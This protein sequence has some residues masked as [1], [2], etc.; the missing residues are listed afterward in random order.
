MPTVAIRPVSEPT[1]LY[2]R[3]ER[4][5]HPQPAY[6]ALDLADGELYADYQADN[7]IPARIWYGVVRTWPIP[8]LAGDEANRLMEHIAPL[9]QRVLDGAS[10]ELGEREANRVGVLNEDAEQAEEQIY[11]EI[12]DW[13]EDP[14][15]QVVEEINVGDWY[16]HG[17]DPCEELGLTAETTDDELPG[18]AA[19]IEEDICLTAEGVV[20]VRGALEWARDRRDELRQELRDQ[21][22]QVVAEIEERLERRDELVRRLAACGDSTRAIGDLAG[23]SHTQVRR[24][25]AGG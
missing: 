4:N 10:I 19:R 6:I 21:L 12:Q 22:V 17:D 8:P 1:A 3:Y 24:I 15:V 16:S 13:C 7:D 20:V 25:V 2:R 14:T 9:A 11:R 5:C 18:I 23:M